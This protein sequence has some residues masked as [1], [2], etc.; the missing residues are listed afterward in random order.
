MMVCDDV[1]LFH[2]MKLNGTDPLWAFVICLVFIA[3]LGQYTSVGMFA[4]R[5]EW[6]AEISHMV[7]LMGFLVGLFVCSVASRVSVHQDSQS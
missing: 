7:W 2:N 1:D 6:F 4:K 3:P 5:F